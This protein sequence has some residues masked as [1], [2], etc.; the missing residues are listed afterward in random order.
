VDNRPKLLGSAAALSRE[1]RNHYVVGSICGADGRWRK[2]KVRVSSSAARE[3]LQA[4]YKQGYMAAKKG[5]QFGSPPLFILA[6]ST[7]L[8]TASPVVTGRRLS[9]GSPEA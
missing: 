5:S 8:A 4:F 2:I 1:M 6:P 9:R 7:L 3:G